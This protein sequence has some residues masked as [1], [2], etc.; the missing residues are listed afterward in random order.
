MIIDYLSL[1]GECYGQSPDQA[2]ATAI[3][4]YKD[5]GLQLKDIQSRAKKLIEEI[6]LET[7]KLRLE[8]FSRQGLLPQAFCNRDV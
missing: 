4:V 8:Y 5:A 3:E 2:I 6:S 1:L 7:G